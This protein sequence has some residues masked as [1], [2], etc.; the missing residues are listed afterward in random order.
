MHQETIKS[1]LERNHQ[2][3][4]GLRSLPIGPRRY[5]W[6]REIKKHLLLEDTSPSLWK[7]VSIDDF[8]CY[9]NHA[10]FFHG[11]SSKL[12]DLATLEE[13]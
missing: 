2:L 8:L 1:L 6:E 4:E 13:A 3:L 7:I 5:S 10:S 12:A 9:R 11:D